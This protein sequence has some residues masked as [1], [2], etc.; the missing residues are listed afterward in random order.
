MMFVSLIALAALGGDPSGLASGRDADLL[1]TRAYIAAYSAG[2]AAS[3]H[4]AI[5]AWARKYNVNCSACHGPVVPR[6]NETGP[7]FKW[8]GYR[9]P[10]EIGENVE[11][12]K[13]QNYLAAGL[14]LQY[15][16]EKTAGEATTTNGFSLP[17]ATVFYAGPFGR[18]FSG[19]VEL[20]HGAENEVERV[21][22]V[23]FLWG[24]EKGYGGFR[25][26]QM[27]YLAEWGLAGF[28][29][30][31]GINPPLAID[32][33]ITSGVPFAL[34]EHQLGLEAYYVSGRNR[35]SG[36]I[37]NGVNAEGMGAVA[38]ADLSKDFVITERE[39]R[40]MGEKISTMLREKYG[41]VQSAP[42]H[43]YV[44]LV[45]Q[46][47]GASSTRPNLAWTFIVLDTDGVNAFA[48]PGGF[49]HIT[50]GALALCSDE[51]ELAGVLG[52]EITHVTAKHTI[53]AI[54]KSKV[55]GGVAEAATRSNV[56]EYMLDRAYAN[57]LENAY[58]RGDEDESDE[59]GI[60]L[61]NTLG[62]APSG[63]GA[64]LTRLSER[65]KDLKEPSG[66]FASHPATKSRVDRLTKQ[67][68][69]EKLA[70][71]ALVA[72]RY[73]ATITYT[74]VPVTVVAGAAGSSS[75]AGGGT[76]TKP[77]P[78]PSPSPSASPTPTPASKS[79]FGLGGISTKLGTDKTST[80]TMA[81]A[82]SRGVNPDRDARGGANPRIVIITL[83]PAELEAFR[84]GISG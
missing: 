50:R 57:L 5:P 10:E 44:S 65:N 37:L 64:F 63:L 11:V 41:V 71:T 16:W 36:Q 15:E 33:P 77:S 74:P 81:S 32:G 17:A 46:I 59:V 62:Y 34:G 66:V 31:V 48:A 53:N 29:R 43:K 9:M 25:V 39:E 6:L 49:I 58:D 23:S 51:A 84:R 2:R 26:G 38:D 22:Q 27:H 47:L 40:D 80:G 30:A 70:A 21:A 45:G 83:T 8:A 67:I 78:T 76:A 56:L 69:S 1:R 73:K 24:K 12:G 82:G 19:F 54:K 72:A 20:E 28:D 42:V 68:K 35:L 4:R 61:A 7:R 3:A 55:A 18:R 13:V 60:R 75:L 79:R 52:H 14:N